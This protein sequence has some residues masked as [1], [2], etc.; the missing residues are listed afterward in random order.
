[1]SSNSLRPA[2]SPTSAC[3]TPPARRGRQSRRAHT[4]QR[5]F[6][7]S[8][9]LKFFLFFK[10]KVKKSSKFCSE[11]ANWTEFLERGAAESARP[12]A[13]AGD[14]SA[15][16]AHG[17]AEAWKI[18]EISANSNDIELFL[19]RK[20]YSKA[21]WETSLRD[22]ESL[23]RCRWWASRTK[24]KRALIPWH[25]ASKNFQKDFQNDLR[26]PFLD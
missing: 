20:P 18:C 21:F 10:L 25:E 24:T 12:R 1:M 16:A 7:I 8:F 5:K 11:K 3:T 13:A 14:G 15:V 22:F 2:S 26:R 23:L 19:A 9:H 17:C 6:L 4:L